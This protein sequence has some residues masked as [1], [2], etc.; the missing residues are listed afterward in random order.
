M[1]GNKYLQK[2]TNSM[3]PV[4]KNLLKYVHLKHWREGLGELLFTFFS[5]GACGGSQGRPINVLEVLERWHL[6]DHGGV[7]IVLEVQ[8]L[9]Q[10]STRV[11][12][13]AG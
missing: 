8:V 11:E 10:H 7:Y 9:G 4:H 12:P 3:A 2:N 13:P 5:S 6:L 1:Y